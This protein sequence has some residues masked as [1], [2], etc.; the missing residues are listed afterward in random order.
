VFKEL[1][2]EIGAEMSH[3][4]DFSNAQSRSGSDF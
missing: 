3:L 1:H 2:N 4:H